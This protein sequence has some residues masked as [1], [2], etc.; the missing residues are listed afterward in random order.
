MVV[1]VALGFLFIY[2]LVP[3]FWLPYAIVELVPKKLQIT[4]QVWLCFYRYCYVFL[5]HPEG[6]S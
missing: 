1:V 3:P 4:M 2:L 5:M 6:Q